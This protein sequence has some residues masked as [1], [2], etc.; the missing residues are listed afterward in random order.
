MV[1]IPLLFKRDKPSLDDYTLTEED[2]NKHFEV[3]PNYVEYFFNL[4]VDDEIDSGTLCELR[5][6]YNV[7]QGTFSWLDKMLDCP[8]SDFEKIKPQYGPDEESGEIC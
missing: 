2:L 1:E 8:T 3:D 4:F 7:E 5:E 6:N